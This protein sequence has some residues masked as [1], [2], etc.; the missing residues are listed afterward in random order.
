MLFGERAAFKSLNH[1]DT[2]RGGIPNAIV[3]RVLAL[4][5]QQ[6]TGKKS[7]RRTM[8]ETDLIALFNLGRQIN[9]FRFTWACRFLLTASNCS[10]ASRN[11]VDAAFESLMQ[12]LGSVVHQRD[13]V[14]EERRLEC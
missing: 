2:Y 12:A 8:N 1:R 7:P 4:A 5:S 14:Q 3:H 6:F 13:R 11:S 9:R 10:N